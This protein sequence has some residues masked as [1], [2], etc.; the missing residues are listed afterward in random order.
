MSLK[1]TERN[2][3][4]MKKSI[5]KTA[6][7]AGCLLLALI[8]AVSA[9]NAAFASAVSVR[10]DE[11][12]YVN[13][14]AEG[15][16]KNVTVSDWLH[17]DENKKQL[18]DK[19]DLKDIENVKSNEEPVQKGNSLTW[20]MN[21]GKDDSG[22]NIYYQGK[23]DKKPPLQVS[24]SYTLNGKSISAEELAGKS[25]KIT[26][27]VDIKNTAA[28]TVDVNGESVTM[29]TPMT[30]VLVAALPTDTF[31]N[32]TLSG[33]K[34]ISDGNNQFVTFLAMPGLEESL[35]LK[36]THIDALKDLDFPESLTITADAADF[37]LGSIA[38]ASTPELLDMDDLED[39]DNL[40]KMKDDLHK[41]KGM[42]DDIEKAD[43][44]KEIRSL[45]TNPDQTAAARLIVDDVFDF[46][47]LDT[48]M[49]DILPD[50]VTDDNIKLYDRI[51]SDLDKADLKYVLDDKVLR[52]LNDRL[53]DENIQKGKQLLKDYDEIE[54][55]NITR[56]NE[57]IHVL[58]HYDS[59]YNT[60]D[61]LLDD[62]RKT[63][64][65]L[66]SGE[67]TLKKLT[68]LG[69]DNSLKNNVAKLSD[70]YETLCSTLGDYGITD[71]SSLIDESMLEDIIRPMVKEFVEKKFPTQRQL[72]A[73]L[74]DHSDPDGHDITPLLSAF[75][76]SKIKNLEK[77]ITQ[78]GVLKQILKLCV[79]KDSGSIILKYGNE[80]TFVTIL[81]NLESNIIDYV[82][83][84]LTEQLS[85]VLTNAAGVQK[86][87]AKDGITSDDLKGIMNSVD[88]AMDNINDLQDDLDDV[89]DDKLTDY[90]DDASDLLRDKDK[91]NYMIKWARK[92]KD[93]KTDMDVNSENIG[94]LRDLLKEYDD[95][96]IRNAKDMIP[97]L[98]KDFDDARP[99]LESLK[100]RLDEPAMNRSLHKL[101]QTTD[102]LL[103]MKDDI[104]SHHEL[105]DIFKHTF[106]PNTVSLFNSTFT[107][108]DDFKQ[109]N[110]I[111]NYVSDVDDLIA[112]KDRY[113][114]LSKQYSIFTQAADG[115]D[116]KL[117][118]VMK[119]E[120]IKKPEKAEVKTV[121]NEQSNGSG[122][123]G[124][125]QNAWN[126]AANKIS[127]LF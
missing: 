45:F 85:D 8:F 41:L 119:T 13:L 127:H 1:S 48:K 30:S 72:N 2:D 100:D 123:W 78:S 73:I 80:N 50:Y 35:D 111:D 58:N 38:I 53:T 59:T 99:I 81:Q 32:V 54:T 93:M 28:H 26:I 64:F 126:K 57:V 16:L 25:G 6:G 122:I 84:A 9:P 70:S 124:W 101:P 114:D 18:P 90:L 116:T 20:M 96:K 3:L 115:T 83:Q 95:P 24:I 79:V 31:Q 23:T 33:G 19:S 66:D 77:Y 118:F 82:T 55:F 117:K 112:R 47:G 37:E 110:S 65:W 97:A 15:K 121:A 75:N 10:K 63:L 67:K 89:D 105:M 103:K 7:R 44:D 4:C 107:T 43:P 61:N 49:L 5:I 42:Q 76:D 104:N 56:L 94:V 106:E 34:L 14:N 27:K 17:S 12:V 91:M 74:T 92:L 120:E 98:Q 11:T 60:M 113:V 39:S 86:S 68:K 69:N 51:T 22:S 52:G 88:T 109:K 87:I 71:P 125:V 108:L 40:N 29:Y 46:Y 36:N 21:S 62:A 102:T